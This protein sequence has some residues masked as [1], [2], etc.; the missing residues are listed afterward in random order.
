MENV[1]KQHL[2][3]EALLEDIK[4]NDG[5]LVFEFSLLIYEK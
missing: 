5:S 3:T 4:Q 1:L 2:Q